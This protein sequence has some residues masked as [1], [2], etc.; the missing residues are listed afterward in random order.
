MILTYSYV[1][2]YLSRS[3]GIIMYDTLGTVVRWKH[4]HATNIFLP[5]NIHHP[6]KILWGEKKT[7]GTTR[8]LIYIYTIVSVN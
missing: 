5:L 8:N 2:F 4:S 1:Q 3:I 6:A 7:E